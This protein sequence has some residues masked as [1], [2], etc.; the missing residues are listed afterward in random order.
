MNCMCHHCPPRTLH[1]TNSRCHIPV[2]QTTARLAFLAMGIPICSYKA[3]RP[4]F[5]SRLP[6][7]YTLY[8][9]E[10]VYALDSSQNYNSARLIGYFA[11]FLNNFIS[12]FSLVAWSRSSRTLP[13]QL[14]P[15]V[16]GTMASLLRT[17]DSV[18]QI[19][20]SEDADSKASEG[21]NKKF[22]TFEELFN[23]LVEV[24]CLDQRN[25]SAGLSFE[26]FSAEPMQQMDMSPAT[27][28][29]IEKDHVPEISE[30]VEERW[31]QSVLKFNTGVCRHNHEAQVECSSQPDWNA[32]NSTR[33]STAPRAQPVLLGHLKVDQS[34]ED[35][36][37]CIMSLVRDTHASSAAITSSP[38]I[39]L[40][41]P[42][43]SQ[44]SSPS[45]SSSFSHFGSRSSSPFISKSNTE[46]TGEK[47]SRKL[48]PLPISLESLRSALLLTKCLPPDFADNKMEME[49]RYS[50]DQEI[51]D[52]D[53]RPQQM[54]WDFP[55]RHA[56]HHQQRVA[57]SGD[58]NTT[59]PAMNNVSS[60][61][62]YN[63]APF[64]TPGGSES[65]AY[66]QM[67]GHSHSPM[68]RS[69]LLTPDSSGSQSSPMSMP[70]GMATLPPQLHSPNYPTQQQYQQVP[71]SFAQVSSET[72]NPRT[73]MAQPA[74]Q[75]AFAGQHSQMM[76]G[77]Q[78]RQPQL[79]DNDSMVGAQNP[80]LLQH[81]QSRHPNQSAV[82]QG[83]SPG[84]GMMAIP[85]SQMH[86]NGIG[87]HIPR[88]NQTGHGKG[89]LNP[90]SASSSSQS[91]PDFVA[92]LVP[93]D[94]FA[95]Q[96]S[97][98]TPN[99]S[100]QYSTANQNTHTN[101][102]TISL[103]IRHPRHKRECSKNLA[104]PINNQIRASSP[105]HANG[106]S[107]NRNSV[108]KSRHGS[109]NSYPSTPSSS[110]SSHHRRKSSCTSVN[111]VNSRAKE[112]EDGFMNFTPADRHKIL[113]G[114]APSGS[115]KTKAKREKE[116]AE[117]RRRLGEAAKQ[118]VLEASGG[119][120]SSL[121]KG[122]SV[123]QHV[124]GDM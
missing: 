36:G 107:P 30:A 10:K 57:S 33:A 29:E 25:S 68:D 4:E 43:N 38:Q 34:Q 5:P 75:I 108:S 41:T 17:T 12:Q 86:T 106:K 3:Y 124:S 44:A 79:F 63:S 119:D 69:P 121:D 96:H 50:Y 53:F 71:L 60:I 39:G 70:M 58:I 11:Y 89:G 118:A 101:E 28:S 15:A 80:N 109:S 91:M 40:R 66:I 37:R 24:D 92:A 22:Y 84:R 31:L 103:A 88:M 56:I 20:T 113:N 90:A 9:F 59:I 77:N 95:A 52:E 94:H 55:P 102:N 93:F 72:V 42:F 112:P 78:M 120:L 8:P 73:V 48:P 61:P 46:T 18:Y 54:P 32:V 49:E 35:N 47:L 105:I 64:L 76:H 6:E 65:S 2:S 21:A 14:K 82:D 81:Q 27:E 26:H 117:K 123:L 23:H 7:V 13:H 87:Q 51:K 97:P 16:T 110:T 85:A 62:K 98:W 100:V 67:N 111:P 19:R 116:E 74:K 45:D 114:V 122:L 1:S 99:S 104:I 115:S 83:V